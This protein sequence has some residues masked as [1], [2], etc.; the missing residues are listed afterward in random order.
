MIPSIPEKYRIGQNSLKNASLL[1]GGF[2]TGGWENITITNMT[3]KSCFGIALLACKFV[4]AGFHPH[5]ASPESGEVSPQG[6]EGVK[7]DS[8]LIT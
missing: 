1:Q 3:P 5:P 4:S 7:R 8:H 2:Y 6:T